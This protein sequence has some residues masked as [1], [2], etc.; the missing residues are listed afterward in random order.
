[1]N[2]QPSKSFRPGSSTEK[3]G[4]TNVFRSEARGGTA[5][6]RRLWNSVIFFLRNEMTGVQTGVRNV[7]PPMSARSG[8]C[9]SFIPRDCSSDMHRQ[10]SSSKQQNVSDEWKGCVVFAARTTC[11]SGKAVASLL[12]VYTET[13]ASLL[14][15][16]GVERLAIRLD[17]CLVVFDGV[18]RFQRIASR[19]YRSDRLCRG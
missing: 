8:L 14:G 11:L 19:T 6:E 5:D 17:F 1:M 9:G 3:D 18:R 12:T 4:H 13:L 16:V 15:S 7:G 2:G 10:S